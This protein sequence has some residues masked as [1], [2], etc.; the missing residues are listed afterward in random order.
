[1]RRSVNGRIEA[2]SDLQ[3]PFIH[4]TLEYVFNDCVFN[5]CVFDRQDGKSTPQRFANPS[6][7]Y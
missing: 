6:V 4:R 1:M 3:Y 7:W 5:D 2:L